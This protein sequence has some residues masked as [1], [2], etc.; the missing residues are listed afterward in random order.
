MRSL[1]GLLV[2]LLVLGGI[3]FG[4]MWALD[5]Y[6]EPTPREITVDLPLDEILND[7][8]TLV[9]DPYAQGTVQRNPADDEVT[10]ATEGAGEAGATD[11]EAA[12]AE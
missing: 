2:L 6:I 7:P 1:I 10:G 11:A 8:E 5:T 4:G 9:D 3:A 12:P